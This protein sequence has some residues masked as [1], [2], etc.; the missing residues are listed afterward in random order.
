MKVRSITKID[1]QKEDANS[2]V[3]RLMAR[4]VDGVNE[5][6]LRTGSPIK[7]LSAKDCVIQVVIKNSQKSIDDFKQEDDEEE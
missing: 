4:D 1:R 3:Y 2:V 7:G 6:V 5:I